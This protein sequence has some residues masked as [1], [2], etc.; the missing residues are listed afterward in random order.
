MSLPSLVIRVR[1]SSPRSRSF[2]P[3]PVQLELTP[4]PNPV[5]GA[6]PASGVAG[7]LAKER[8]ARGVGSDGDDRTS[9]PPVFLRPLRACVMLIFPSL[10]SHHSLRPESRSDFRARSWNRSLERQAD[11]RPVDIQGGKGSVGRCFVSILNQS[12]QRHPSLPRSTQE[13]RAG[14]VGSTREAGGGGGRAEC[15]ADVS[16]DRRPSF[17]L[18]LQPSLAHPFNHQSVRLPSLGTWSSRCGDVCTGIDG[19]R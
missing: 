14:S 12:L 6:K 15:E 2:S 16:R 13:E 19:S 11:A 18:A 10:R 9:P 17:A 3:S 5:A 7:T 1:P 4:P 8:E